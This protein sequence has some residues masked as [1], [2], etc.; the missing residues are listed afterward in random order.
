VECEKNPITTE[1]LIIKKTIGS[2][3]KLILKNLYKKI[4]KEKYIKKKEIEFNITCI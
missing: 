2:L 1:T 3:F 4:C